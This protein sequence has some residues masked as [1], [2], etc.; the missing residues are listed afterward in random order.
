MIALPVTSCD[1]CGL[2]CYGQAALPVSYYLG[3]AKREAAGLP[4]HVLKE[5]VAMHTVFSRDGWPP[6]ESPCVWF[7]ATT[8]RCVHYE[9]RPTICRDTIAPGDE[10]CMHIR[11]MGGKDHE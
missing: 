6:D 8:R 5:L 10:D 9:H 3:A 11:R 1:D 2:C 7:D 4:T